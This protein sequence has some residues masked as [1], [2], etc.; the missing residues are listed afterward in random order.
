MAVG[1]VAVAAAMAMTH[2]SGG[3]PLTLASAPAVVVTAKAEP[4]RARQP[5]DSQ[6]AVDVEGGTVW[7]E[8]WLQADQQGR[9]WG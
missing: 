2:T 9:R 4:S 3:P 8:P 7:H 6:P 5:A 1:A